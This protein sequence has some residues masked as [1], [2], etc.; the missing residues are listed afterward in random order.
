MVHHSTSQGVWGKATIP[1]RIEKEEEKWWE[2]T[3]LTDFDIFGGKYKKSFYI[4][5]NFWKRLI[6]NLSHGSQLNFSKFADN[7]TTTVK[8]PREKKIPTTNKKL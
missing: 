8:K 5:I 4:E 6:K 7:T 3:S 1:N 2:I